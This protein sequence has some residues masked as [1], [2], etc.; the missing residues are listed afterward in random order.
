MTIVAVIKKT[1]QVLRNDPER[2]RLCA[3]GQALKKTKGDEKQGGYECFY[4][5]LRY[6]SKY[7]MIFT[8][9]CRHPGLENSDIQPLLKDI[10]RYSSKIC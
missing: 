9:A 2:I 10:A 4:H 1:I 5:R 7:L 8:Q 6:V 3:C